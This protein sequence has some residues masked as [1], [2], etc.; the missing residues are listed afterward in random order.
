MH[1]NWGQMLFNEMNVQQKW[2]IVTD[3]LNGGRK[4]DCNCKTIW[5]AGQ[6]RLDLKIHIFLDLSWSLNTH[7]VFETNIIVCTSKKLTEKFIQ[8]TLS[9]LDWINM[10]IAFY[11]RTKFG[12]CWALICIFCIMSIYVISCLVV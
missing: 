10:Q 2:I 9:V 12:L 1:S 5:N 7:V 8:F 3:L 6:M 4:I 11:V